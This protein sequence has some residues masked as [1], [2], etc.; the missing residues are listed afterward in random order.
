MTATGFH[1]WNLNRPPEPV[2]PEARLDGLDQ[3]N[4]AGH[5]STRRGLGSQT[6]IAIAAA[7]QPDDAPT[8]NAVKNAMVIIHPSCVGPFGN[9]LLR[10]SFPDVLRARSRAA[11]LNERVAVRAGPRP[12]RR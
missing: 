12:K 7:A 9:D 1:N 8:T 6:V 10:G 3:P 11:A 4:P 5:T 2:L